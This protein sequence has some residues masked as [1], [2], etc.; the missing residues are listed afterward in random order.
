MKQICL[1]GPVDKRVIAYPLLKVLM[2]L[3]KTLI[4]ADDGVYRRFD[5]EFRMRFAFGNSEFII[6][7]QVSPVLLA[8]IEGLAP[9]FDFV[10]FITNNELP[11]A[12]DKIIYCR[13]TEKAIIS[14]GTLSALEDQDFTEVYVTFSRLRDSS[15]LK[16]E[17]SKA[18]MSYIWDCENA[19]RFSVLKDQGV[20]FM[21]EKFFQ[22]ELGVPKTTIKGL[23]AREG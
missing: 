7:P 5:D 23:L 11:S 22:T 20:A 3:G 1:L 21:L 8:E 14:N 2:F 6:T 4:I 16:V 9:S 10:L 17:P 19:K 12:C 13:D 15:L 18:L